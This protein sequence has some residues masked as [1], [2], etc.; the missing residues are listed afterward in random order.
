MIFAIVAVIVIAVIAF[1]I[2]VIS[3][4]KSDGPQR[5]VMFDAENS[6]SCESADKRYELLSKAGLSGTYLSKKKGITL[7]GQEEKRWGKV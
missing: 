6:N 7:D 2:F 1:L 4:K 5:T 3:P